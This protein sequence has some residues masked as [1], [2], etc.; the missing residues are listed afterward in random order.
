M[1]YLIEYILSDLWWTR[2]WTYH[3]EYCASIKMHLLIPHYPDVV[4]S[5]KYPFG[6]VP[7]EV[8]V[9][10]VSFREQVT[11]FCLTHMRKMGERW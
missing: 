7:G 2:A 8:K 10:A 4:K 11:R 9:H 3:E 6:D 5:Q 1:I